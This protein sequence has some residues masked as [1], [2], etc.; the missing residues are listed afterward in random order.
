MITQPKCIGVC[1]DNTG[2]THEEQK[3][4]RHLNCVFAFCN[5]GALLSL[6]Y[7]F[8]KQAAGEQAA[9]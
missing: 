6:I 7:G 4:K 1:D 2:A 8:R 9:A 3:A 5:I